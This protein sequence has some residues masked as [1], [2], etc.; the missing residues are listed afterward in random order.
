MSER[1]NLLKE[2]FP[3]SSTTAAGLA[4][5]SACLACKSETEYLGLADESSRDIDDISEPAGSEGTASSNE[6]VD[7]PYTRRVPTADGQPSDLLTPDQPLLKS[8]TFIDGT[9]MFKE[10]EAEAKAEAKAILTARQ[11]SKEAASQG[12]HSKQASRTSA[13]KGGVFPLPFHQISKACILS[14]FTMG[15]RQLLF[16]IGKFNY[17]NANMWWGAHDSTQKVQRTTGQHAE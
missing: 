7:I 9:Q 16:K 1:E 14:G 3:E 10:A 12:T 13:P 5:Y 4:L 2:V 15:I 8:F 6:A 11:K 17:R